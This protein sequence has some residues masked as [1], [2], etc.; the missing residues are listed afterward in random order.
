M[1]PHLHLLQTDSA[2]N[3][4][5]VCGWTFPH[6]SCPAVVSEYSHR[7]QV[8]EEQKQERGA[9]GSCAVVVGLSKLCSINPTS[10]ASKSCC[11]ALKSSVKK[12][13]EF[14]LSSSAFQVINPNY[15]FP[16]MFFLPSCNVKAALCIDRSLWVHSDLVLACMEP[17][18]FLNCP[19][20]TANALGHLYSLY[21]ISNRTILFQL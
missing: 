1:M 7:L 19:K 14:P 20:Q 2:W 16:Q 13:A 21:F 18:G 4:T 12:S 5:A 9:F 8:L 10:S 17:E 3:I 15:F 6:T 11:W